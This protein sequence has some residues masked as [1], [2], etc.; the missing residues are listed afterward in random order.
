MNLFKLDIEVKKF[1]VRQF[2]E[3]DINY[4]QFTENIYLT[5]SYVLLACDEKIRVF[6]I[7]P[8]SS[9]NEISAIIIITIVGID[10]SIRSDA[11]VL[12]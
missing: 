11:T 7:P 1:R 6:R 2:P 9:D 10:L 5:P 12:I 8:V 3:D 4:G